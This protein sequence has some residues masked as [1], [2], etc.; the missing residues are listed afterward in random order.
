MKHIRTKLDASANAVLS[1]TDLE[2]GRSY[3]GLISAVKEGLINESAI[4]QSLCRL[5]KA[6]F[7]LGEMDDTT[8]GISCQTVCCRVMH[9]SSWLYKWHVR[10]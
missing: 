1:G 5:M 2:C 7:E 8:R 10:V 4:D 6:R 3:T 9:I